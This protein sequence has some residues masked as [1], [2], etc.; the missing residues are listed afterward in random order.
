MDLSAVQND[1]EAGPPN[2]SD[3]HPSNES[4]SSNPHP[5]GQPFDTNMSLSK[6]APPPDDVNNASKESLISPDL[7]TDDDY[8][9]DESGV[10]IRHNRSGTMNEY[11]NIDDIE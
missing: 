10:D 1:E 2:N 7:Q 9:S 11:N 5:E 3:E 4:R 6:L 8:H